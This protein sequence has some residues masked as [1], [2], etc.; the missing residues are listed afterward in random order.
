MLT[1]KHER[2]TDR[3]ALSSTYVQSVQRDRHTA[4]TYNHKKAD[5][6]QADMGKNSDTKDRNDHSP[7]QTTKKIDRVNQT[8]KMIEAN[9]AIRKSKLPNYRH[10]RIPVNSKFNMSYLTTQLEDYHDKEVLTFIEY[11]WPIS[12]SDKLSDNTGDNYK[13]HI[14]HKGATEYPH[15]ID[16]YLDKEIQEGAIVGPVLDNSFLK[17]ITVSPLNSRPKR[18]SD[19]RRILLD[20]SFPKGGGV[21]SGIEKDK[22]LGEPAK[23][24][25]PNV[26]TL[27]ELVKATGRGCA[28]YKRDLRRAYRQLPIDPGDIHHLGY[29]WRGEVYLDRVC[30]MGL[31]TSAYI[32][33]RCTNMVT[34]ICKQHKV[35]VVNYLDDFGGASHWST[36]ESD[37]EQLGNILRSCG[38]EESKTKA[39]QPSTR[40]IFLGVY[41]DTVKMTLEVTEERLQETLHDLDQWIAA[42]VID[43]HTLQEIIGKLNFIAACV[44]PGR[45]FITRLLNVLR[46]LPATGKIVTPEEMVKDLIWWKTFLPT[47]NGVSMMVLEEWA[48]PDAEL[49]TDACLEG[50]G[51]WFQGEYFHLEF[52]EHVK[53]AAGSIN[54]LELLT[55]AIAL[56]IW[57]QKFRGKRIRI[58]CDNLTSVELINHGRAKKQFL[59]SCLREI[60]Y[61]SARGEFE[62]KGVHIEGQKIKIPDLLSR[63]GSGNKVREEFRQLTNDKNTV[64]KYVYPGLC[65]F[66]HNW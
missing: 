63:W 42:K 49:A 21:N 10:C 61:V 43:R 28:L 13:R 4:N 52:P 45:V 18:E 58:Q 8:N 16:K 55:I 50:C 53:T 26:D 5:D 33:Q 22:Y 15:E 24:R 30:P 3:H 40:M 23:V 32:C 25:L 64:E 12:F 9:R 2:Q 17:E 46:D 62:V 19:E 41:F 56:K 47:Y 11:G 66:S 38:L 36:A 57:K 60:C 31:R 54:A 14:N 29:R 7:T 51:G 35:N 65:E 6:K 27:V 44:R 1:D 34:Y 20:L 39:C 37:F 59:Q 48:S